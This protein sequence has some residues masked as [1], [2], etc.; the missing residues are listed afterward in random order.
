MT[1][2]KLLTL[3]LASL[4]I[5]TAPPVHAQSGSIQSEPLTAPPPNAVY[6][7]APANTDAPVPLDG[8]PVPQSTAPSQPRRARSNAPQPAYQQP[9]YQPQA[10]HSSS[11]YTASAA[12]SNS[13]SSQQDLI[14][15]ADVTLKYMRGNKDY[16]ELDRY[17]ARA[18]AVYVIPQLIKAAFFFG[19]EGGDGV[20]LARLPDGT[21][22]APSFSVIGSASFGLQAGAKSSEIVFFIMTDKG[23][24]AILNR[25]VKLGAG[26]ASR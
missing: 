20:M 10:A 1:Y 14:N 13:T 16:A 15:R 23:L 3:S 12:P 24:N 17:M 7:T 26:S 9:T 2:A 18:K 6:T 22:S 19:G 21:W 25:D 8:S 11:S 5:A 4:L